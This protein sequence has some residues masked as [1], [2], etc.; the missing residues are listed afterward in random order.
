[1]ED[2]GAEAGAEKGDRRIETGQDRDEN[3]RAEH[4][5]DVLE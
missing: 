2:E 1:V 3:R 4:G 5:E